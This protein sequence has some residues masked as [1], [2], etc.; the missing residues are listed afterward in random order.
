MPFAKSDGVKIYYE[1]RGSGEPL[2]LLPGQAS[3]HSSWNDVAGDYTGTHQVVL[4][5]YRGT[6][7][8]DMPTT[9]PYSTRL[10]ANDIIAVLD[11]AGFDRAHVFG[12]SFGGRVGQW[13]G[14]DHSD[15]LGG[16]VL[17]CTTPGNAHGVKRPDDV[18]AFFARPPED[19]EVAFRKRMELFV[20]DRFY[21]EHPD[22]VELFKQR[23]AA[24]RIPPEVSDQ[25]EIASEGHDSWD[26]LPEITAPTLV[27]HGTQ[28]RLNA[29]GNGPLLASRIPGAELHMVEGARHLF[30]VEF[31]DETRDTILDFLSRNSISTITE[32]ATPSRNH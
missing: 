1:L 5:D 9:P 20:T 3:D 25:H 2:V 28:D 11:D 29:S 8:S 32:R 7:Q 6:G 24:A 16:L 30:Y 31:R 17:G 10:F 21:D 14:I 4:V 19:P 18:V 27:I 23:R 12:I 26:H 22:W 13:L 15:R